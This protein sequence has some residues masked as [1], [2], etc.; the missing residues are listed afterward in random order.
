[1]IDTQT[2]KDVWR[3]Y[4]DQIDA[5]DSIL[6]QTRIYKDAVTF[7]NKILL[8]PYREEVVL[9]FPFFIKEYHPGD[10]G[11]IEFND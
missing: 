8:S 2:L 7:V 9:P 11:W 10:P 3:Y 5:A 4:Q 1:M 6:K